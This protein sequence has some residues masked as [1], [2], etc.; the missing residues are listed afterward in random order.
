MR[1][2]RLAR[3]NRAFPLTILLLAPV[4]NAG[5]IE[6]VAPGGSIQ[7]AID[8]VENGGFVHV[9]AGEYD[10]CISVPLGRQVTVVALGGP[11]VTTITCGFG[12]RAVSVDGTLDLRG[13]TITH[14]GFGGGG[15]RVEGTFTG[16]DL[17]LLDM[18]ESTAPGAGVSVFDGVAT[19]IDVTFDQVAT[20]SN[21][22]AISVD[23]NGI[24]TVLGAR[25]SGAA[26]AGN[27][28]AIYVRDGF[29][30]AV[31]VVIDGS[32]RP[33]TARNG[34]G[35]YVATTGDVSLTQ[36]TIL[37]AH[38]SLDG[39]GMYIE[40]RAR[41]VL[42]SGLSIDGNSAT[43]DGGGVFV[44]GPLA[45]LGGSV[46]GNDAAEGGGGLYID[47]GSVDLRGTSVSDNT[48]GGKPEL[49]GWPSGA[50][51]FV[52]GGDLI[53]GDCTIASNIAGSVEAL[54]GG[55]YITDRSTWASTGD[56]ISGNTARDGG[57]VWVRGATSVELRQSQLSTNDAIG[58]VGGGLYL[59]DDATV[60]NTVFDANNADVD[61]GGIYVDDDA[62]LTLTTSDVRD[63][64]ANNG[65][66]GGLFVG[67]GAT[68]DARGVRIEGNQATRGAGGG[69]HYAGTDAFGGLTLET[70]LIADN[71]APTGAGLSLLEGTLTID[72]SWIVRNTSTGDGG[73][74]R[75]FGGHDTL[76]TR[77]VLC[78]NEAGR[79]GGVFLQGSFGDR[80]FVNVALQGND[81]LTAGGAVFDG[82]FADGADTPI[83][84][85]AYT[86]AVGNSGPPTLAGFVADT[87]V[88]NDSVID[89]TDSVLDT[90]G[91]HHLAGLGVDPA[92][93]QGRGL[94]FFG[95]VGATFNATDPLVGEDSN[96]V[97][98]PDI[99]GYDGGVPDCLDD[100]LRSMASL[101]DGG[102][103]L[104][105]F[106]GFGVGAGVPSG[107]PGAYDS[108]FREESPFSDGV[109]LAQGDCA[110]DLANVSPLIDEVR[111]NGLDDDCALGDDLD[112]D[113]DGYLAEA[114]G[115]ADCID[116]NPA[117]NP[118][119]EETWGDGV[120][121]NCDDREDDDEDGDGFDD[122]VD[123]DDGDSTIGPHAIDIP[124]DGID[125]D[126][127]G[128]NDFDADGDLASAVD[129]G[130]DDCDD[131]DPEIGP[132]EV[133]IWYDGVDQ[134]CDGADDFDQDGDLYQDIEHGGND[135][136]DDRPEINPGSAE[137]A[138]DG[139]DQDCSGGDLV[140]LDGDGFAAEVAGGNDCD[141]TR[142]DVYPGAP[143]L[144][145]GDDNDC[146]G[147]GDP[148]TDGDGILDHWENLF[149]TDPTEGDT[150]NDFIGDRAEWG[151]DDEA[152]IDTDGDG[153]YDVL[154]EDSDNDTITDQLEANVGD[155]DG[156]GIPNY[157]DD[158]DDGDRL[159]TQAEYNG[160][161]DSDGDGA[162]DYLDRD[163]D[164]DG[165]IDGVDPAPTDRGGD[166]FDPNESPSTP[167]KYGFGCSTTGSG[168]GL[169]GLALALG[170][171]LARR[172]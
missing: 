91:T 105:G 84:S 167:D 136:D 142:A 30:D 68:L 22:G 135:C 156:N 52:D 110:P 25:I 97:S 33:I 65:S 62:D 35:V 45:M 106:G 32:A 1:P 48:A 145:D 115:G 164:N 47:G 69:V 127:D 129:F 28:G 18:L 112:G 113:G 16:Q 3:G 170:L 71:I 11:D 108:I 151:D 95:T 24:L 137:I 74:L 34:G 131:L 172:R 126:C 123:C 50:G 83:T 165:V 53:T 149:G 121:Q 128:A 72:S 147:V 56:M 14:R 55:L 93:F 100:D 146:D 43:R 5:V 102:G 7:G 132:T 38:A 39:G 122:G 54:G 150:D 13:F 58:G 66:G 144:L 49:D 118:D 163:S 86:T 155:T 107:A 168:S 134:N 17:A 6:S 10:A 120:D 82:G 4:A 152:P 140:D 148:D 59:D 23:E 9:E 166:G 159:S 109:Q 15:I 26:A 133:E 70:T 117:A 21:G 87:D 19:L 64:L 61:G 76:V 116:F 88:A 138:Y 98:D 157:R 130:G 46:D 75:V 158:D 37:N 96:V 101:S 99:R 92:Q 41:T 36:A 29:L 114:I 8:R 139:I 171:L 63:N 73:G 81:A 90:N 143:E 20:S 160:G 57:G 111:A 94:V 141:D 79:G 40:E 2:R 162:P 104:R 85:F 51:L 67:D 125:H 169:T 78:G 89:L 77:T 44:R 119:A 154:D 161:V 60:S 124:Y 80:R 27:G 31:D 42:G 103:A 12:D 153:I